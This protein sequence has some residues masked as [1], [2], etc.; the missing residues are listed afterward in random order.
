ML[1]GVRSKENS[2][3]SK[4]WM[5]VVALRA[6]NLLSDEK[7]EDEVIVITELLPQA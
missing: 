2:N 3:W 1:T 6:N 4:A 7:A 5:D